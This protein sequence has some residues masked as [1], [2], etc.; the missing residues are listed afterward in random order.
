MVSRAACVLILKLIISYP[1]L[2]KG[3]IRL[4]SLYQMQGKQLA[5][6]NIY[7]IGLQT[8]SV[9]K[10]HYYL[11]LKGKKTATR[12][13]ERRVDFLVKLPIQIS[14]EIILELPKE[15]KLI[16]LNGISHMWRKRTRNCAKAWSTLQVTGNVYDL[17]TV[18]AASVTIHVE[19]LTIDTSNLMLWKKYI[20]GIRN[21]RFGNIKTLCMTG[22]LS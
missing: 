20:T 6:I 17:R 21:N 12:C 18:L 22:M 5:A 19:N 15:S 7:N 10:E 9:D 4:G 14:N 11:M 8:V 3:Y 2:A 1:T 13:S 16:C